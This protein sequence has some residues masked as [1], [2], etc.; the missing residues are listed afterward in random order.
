MGT[1]KKKRQQKSA[2]KKTEQVGLK[3]VQPM[4]GRGRQDKANPEEGTFDSAGKRQKVDELGDFNIEAAR[5][6]DGKHDNGKEG[7]G[8]EKKKSVP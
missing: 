3:E 4:A 7:V 8:K 2:G 1:Y 5:G 6:G